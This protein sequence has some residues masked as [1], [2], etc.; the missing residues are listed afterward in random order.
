M[1]I[2]AERPSIISINRVYRFHVSRWLPTTRPNPWRFGVLDLMSWP[3]DFCPFRH[4]R[5]SSWSPNIFPPNFWRT[6]YDLDQITDHRTVRNVPKN[7]R[8]AR[9]HKQKSSQAHQRFFGLTI[10]LPRSA[11]VRLFP[12]TRLHC[13]KM[14]KKIPFFLH[15]KWFW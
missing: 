7:K 15:V 11:A 8:V 14:K 9:K 6:V 13:D 2:A 3:R 12:R 4:D 5:R 10:S 1:L